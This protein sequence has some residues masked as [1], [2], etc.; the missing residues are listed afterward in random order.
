MG[1]FLTLEELVAEEVERSSKTSC[2]GGL[3]NK[4]RVFDL[5]CDTIARLAAVEDPRILPDFAEHD[6]A[7]PPGRM[8]S[9]GSNAAQVSLE[10]MQAFNW[11]QCFAAFVPDEFQGDEAW[12]V[13]NC[14][15]Q[16]FERELEQNAENMQRV[17]TM[18]DIETAF[19]A[20][21]TAAMLT[22]EGASFL[23][24]N[25]HAEARLD[26]LAEARVHM[27]ALTWN[28]RNALG[29]GNETSDGLTALGRTVVRELERREIVVDVSHLNE[30]GFRD[31]CATAQQPFAASHSN[32]RVVCDHPRNLADWQLREIADRGGILGLNI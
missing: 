15:R 4:T 13:F 21:K 29:S 22:V 20:S 28:G 23:E 11:C 25:K 30:R 9:L 17:E 26:T 7:L 24:D 31:A 3:S 10:R 19:G 2:E 1:A 32:A 16:R 8:S 12:A 18:I 14:L 6:A 27:V 5:H